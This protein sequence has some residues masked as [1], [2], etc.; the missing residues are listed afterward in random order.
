[1]RFNPMIF[2]LDETTDLGSDT[3]TS[4]RRPHVSRNPL[5]GSGAVDSESTWEKTQTT[6]TT[7]S[8]QNNGSAS[9]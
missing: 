7:K 8:P 3:A 9:Q 2:S 5:H 1:M 6:L 4:H